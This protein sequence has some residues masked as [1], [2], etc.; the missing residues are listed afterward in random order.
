M[1]LD[2]LFLQDHF[3]L[4]WN[5]FKYTLALNKYDYPSFFPDGNS[6]LNF[7]DTLIRYIVRNFCD[8]LLKLWTFY[9]LPTIFPLSVGFG[10][11]IKSVGLLLT[12]K[13]QI[14]LNDLEKWI[15]NVDSA[16]HPFSTC[17][18]QQGGISF[19]FLWPF[20]R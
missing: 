9:G 11:L 18:C 10:N 15:K 1:L 19:L 12:E 4:S 17:Y 13:I 2:T 16:Y 6:F 8:P 5:L 14:Y 20:C 3:S 7:A